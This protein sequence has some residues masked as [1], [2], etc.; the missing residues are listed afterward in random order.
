MKAFTEFKDNLSKVAVSRA[1]MHILKRVLG[2][3]IG[4]HFM[5]PGLNL[6]TM[7]ISNGNSLMKVLK[8]R[9]N[10]DSPLC[11][12]S[13]RRQA[14]RQGDRSHDDLLAPPPSRHQPTQH[15]QPHT[16]TEL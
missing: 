16:G 5:A 8:I 15:Q 12:R 7:V 4:A 9:R 14:D 2:T 10:T 11:D 3:K 1:Q 6:T 13:W